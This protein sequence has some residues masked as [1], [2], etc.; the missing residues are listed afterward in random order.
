MMKRYDVAVVGGGPSGLNVSKRLAE[1]GLDVLLLERKSEIGTHVICTGIL[2]KEV[3][4]KF[5]LAG[6]SV[7]REIK[8]VKVV[9][10][11]GS[12]MTYQHPAPFAYVVDRKKFDKYLAQEADSKGVEIELEN[13]VLDIA[14]NR[15]D[16]EVTTKVEGGGLRKFS[17][18]LAVIATGIDTHLNKKLGLGYPKDFLNGAQAE[19]EIENNDSTAVFVG[20]NIALGA[21]AWAV[22]TADRRVRIGLLTENDPI[23]CFERLME[24]FYPEKTG[25]LD[26][27]RIQVK[28]IAQG[29]VSKSY[30]DRVIAL[31][32]AA[33]QVKTTTGGGIYFGLLCSEIAS[34]VIMKSYQAGSF[35]SS[36]LAE[37]EKFWK[38][39]IQKEIVIGYY[40]RRIWARLNDM[41]VEKIFQIA[42]SDGIIPL[43]RDKGN[44]DWHSDL[45]LTLI[46]K[47]P[48]FSIFRE[49]QESPIFQS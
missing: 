16:V 13:R 12:S 8:N 37:Y 33:G 24:K 9:S 14:V 15:N 31:G 22:P 3:F 41:Q 21:F 49:I 17:A 10:P 25:D 36:R 1:R 6:D 42:R 18:K 32:E 34:E 45:I 43:I 26:K 40:A 35:K 38:R 4:Q 11:Y 39:A 29:L 2:G 7:L 23:V 28:A 27:K 48:F 44:F 46:K 5:D 47:F 20:K 30:G 19:I